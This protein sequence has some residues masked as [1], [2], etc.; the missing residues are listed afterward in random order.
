M[1]A[2]RYQQ[3]KNI[4][5]HVLDSPVSERESVLSSRCSGDAELESDVR[6][7]LAARKPK[8]EVCW[9]RH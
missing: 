9:M 3:V 8:R 6:R 7:L 2:D 5:N 1:T 4:F